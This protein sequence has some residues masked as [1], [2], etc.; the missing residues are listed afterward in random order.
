M[1]NIVYEKENARILDNV[2]FVFK[3]GEQWCILGPNGAG[4]STLISILCAY[5]WPLSG[6]ATVLDRKVGQGISAWRY[7]ERIGLF[8]PAL[9]KELCVYHPA[10][11]ALEVVLTGSDDS[12]ASYHDYTPRQA[13]A[14]RLMEN[15]HSSIPPHRPFGR[16]SAGEQRKILLLRALMKEPEILI[17]DEPYE[18][19]DIPNRYEIE[20]IWQ[21]T[22]ETRQ[23]HTL[24]V[25]HRIEEIHPLTTHVLLL[26][27]GQVFFQ[28]LLEEALQSERISELYDMKLSIHNKH[29]RY[30]CAIV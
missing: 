24:C 25:L 26:K 11:T 7:R 14:R 4:K 13:Q 28:G 1:Q 19:L 20:Q 3:P 27:K 17:L 23:L 22:I 30:F 16:L 2:S 21:R 9:Q 8:Q 29:G 12:L 10:I 15:F 6:Q 5:S 18:S